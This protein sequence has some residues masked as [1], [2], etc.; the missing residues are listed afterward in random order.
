MMVLYQWYV[1]FLEVFYIVD[2][3]QKM[4]D[5]LDKE[6]GVIGNGMD[7]GLTKNLSRQN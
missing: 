2:I 6:F 3:D 1:L 5:M 4:L 7:Y